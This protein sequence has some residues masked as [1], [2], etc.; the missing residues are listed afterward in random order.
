MTG[1]R[2]REISVVL[3]LVLMVMLGAI[4]VVFVSQPSALPGA[5]AT[6]TL[7][8]G[9][10]S[11][12][13]TAAA[14]PT[15]SAAATPTGGA[16]PTGEPTG[17]PTATPT[18]AGPTP[19]P[20]Q[21]DFLDVG[22]D[23]TDTGGEGDVPLPRYFTLTVD[24]PGRIEASV[25]EVSFGRVRLCL[26]RGDPSDVRDNECQTDRRPA[27]SRDVATAG[28]TTWTVSLIGSQA[29][30]SPTV[31]LRLRWP[32]ADARIA[33]SGFRFQGSEIQNYNGFMAEVDSA[34]DGSIN[35]SATFDDG[36]GGSYP[37]RLIIEQVGGGPAQPYAVESEGTELHPGTEVSGSRRYRITLEG[38]HSVA[39]QLVRL[40]ADI[41]WP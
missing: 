2:L 35:V 30:A 5:S 34:S 41:D 6:P 15:A 3:A 33:L 18:D 36:Q 11:P 37:Y 21:I 22:L 16:T 27:L 14:T 32:T 12:G 31:D 7:F 23:T 20:R 24:G 38:R 10:T 4:I 39:E 29:G 26:W 1:R 28:P 13:S 19:A 9:A 8:A 17:Q 25:Q 40:T